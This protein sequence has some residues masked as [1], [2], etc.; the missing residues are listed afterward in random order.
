[1]TKIAALTSRIM[2]DR[3]SAP[4]GLAPLLIITVQLM[5]FPRYVKKVLTSFEQAW[6][7]LFSKW[8][9]KWR[10]RFN[11]MD[12]KMFQVFDTSAQDITARK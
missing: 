1:M 3:E 12:M 5:Q 7:I 6:H 10:G 8:T 4:A 9:D 2:A 11:T